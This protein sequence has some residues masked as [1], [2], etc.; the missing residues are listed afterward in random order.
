MSLHRLGIGS[1][2]PLSPMRRQFSSPL[3][4]S[5]PLLSI[6]RSDISVAAITTTTTD[7]DDGDGYIDI[8]DDDYQ[9]RDEDEESH[10]PGS[11]QDL[12]DHLTQ[13]SKDVLI[14]RLG[15]LVQRLS[16]TGGGGR[17]VNETIIS[18]LHARVD[19]MEKV[20]AAAAAP[21]SSG[22]VRAA[23]QVGSR[24]RPAALQQSISMPFVLPPV[25]GDD[26]GDNGQHHQGLW[27]GMPVPGWLAPRFPDLLTPTTTIT[28][29]PVSTVKQQMGA[30]AKGPKKAKEDVAAERRVAD[31]I[32]EL[33]EKLV[34]ILQGLKARREESDHLH[35]LLV[36]RAESAAARIMELEK[37]VFDL[38][39]EVSGNESELKH[40]RLKL[41]AVETQFVPAEADPELVR[42]IEKWK[43]DW[44]SLRDKMSM[45]K[46]GRR[47][48][49]QLRPR[50]L[51]DGDGD[52]EES[53]FSA[54]TDVSMMVQE[55]RSPSVR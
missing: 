46:K 11:H 12:N 34:S 43:A 3:F 42:S 37:E 47:S 44:T 28:A 21:S 8:D 29:E 55:S 5:S 26:D 17:I 48:R 27:S 36:E 6:M 14:E 32:G 38:E 2:S 54:M 15:D 1:L 24:P 35:A 51:G 7:D 50:G 41:R 39:D 10:T 13:D 19:E 30:G 9:S 49:I 40:L 33:D 20:L 52:G 22:K 25:D 16:S 31:E 18:M 53:T 23:A 4:R 45:R